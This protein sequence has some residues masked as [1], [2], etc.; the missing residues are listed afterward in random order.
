MKEGQVFTVMSSYNA[1]NGIPTTASPFLLTELLR[2]KWGFR[3]YV[4][5][6][7]GAIEDITRGHQFVPTPAEAA[8]LAVNAGCDVECGNILQR[9]L[10]EAVKNLFI[11]ESAL[12]ESLIRAFTG[13]V[14]LGEFDPPE[15]NPY[16]QTPVSCLDSPAHRELAREA[17]R[18]SVVLFKNDN[19]T[20]PLDKSSLKSI[21]VIGPMAC[22]CQLGNYSGGPQFMVS[23]LKA[24]NDYFGVTPGPTYYKNADDFTRF[25]R[26]P[27]AGGIA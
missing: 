20:L 12:D 7:C 22:L 25:R 17:A 16:S 1:L 23:P 4:V 27:G 19:N 24:I 11:G 14:L 18:Q 15:Q 9:Y 5:T 26:R 2:D 3:G 6:D 8:A 21:A 10:G 13:R